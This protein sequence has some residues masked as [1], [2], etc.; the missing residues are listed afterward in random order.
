MN[1]VHF[2]SADPRFC[3]SDEKGRTFS[4]NE[5]KV[6]CDKCKYALTK[7]DYTNLKSRLT[8]AINSKDHKRIVDECDRAL[9]IFDEKGYP[10][11]WSRWQ[12]AK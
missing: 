10:D 4:M 1:S 2:H 5:S 7:S 6:T 3:G 11:D 12:R 8:R 9:A